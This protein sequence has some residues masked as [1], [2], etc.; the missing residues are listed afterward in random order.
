M[1]NNIVFFHEHVNGD[2]FLS[3]ILVKQIIDA[4]KSNNITYYYT[5][6]RAVVSHCLDLGIPDENFNIIKFPQTNQFFYIIDNILFIN[7]WIG[8]TTETD[9][10][11]NITCALCLNNLIPKYN[12]LINK[13]NK[14]L[15]MN[16]QLLNEINNK[17]PYLPLDNKVY[18]SKFI[19]DF[20]AENK[21]KY[22]KIVLICNNNPTTFISTIGITKS[23]LLYI[24]Q[25]IPNYLFI[26]FET[27]ILQRDNVI[28]IK[29]IYEKMN[30]QITNNWGIMFP[31]LSKL[32]DKVILLPTGPSLACFNNQTIKNKFMIL[33]DFSQ[34]GNPGNCFH[35][36]N[37]NNKLCTSRFDWDITVMNVD[38]NDK[39]INNKICYFIESFLQ[40]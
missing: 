14:E 36:N 8:I 21:Q 6:P 4:T 13:L 35:C 18:N 22:E 33:F 32:A 10:D 26:T 12:I 1:F 30:I 29:Q 27:T 17:S 20:I 28:S 37:H 24:T 31:L 34:S 2:C 39:N 19:E 23:Y 7:V 40:K 3:R 5:A 16:I 11:S 38:Y 15:N 9:L 25:Q